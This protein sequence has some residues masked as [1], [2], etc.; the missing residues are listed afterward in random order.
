MERC[1]NNL[2]L[3]HILLILVNLGLGFISS[4]LMAG[5]TSL[6]DILFP[7]FILPLFIL[8]ELVLIWRLAKHFKLK[9][10]LEKASLGL[11][12][13]IVSCLTLTFYFA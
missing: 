8:A 1:F 10:V 6:L 13:F 12:G 2:T 9:R 11:I 5:S 3:N 7:Y 4:S